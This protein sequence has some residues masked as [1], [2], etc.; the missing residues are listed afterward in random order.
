M[1]VFE[2]SYMTLVNSGSYI[3]CRESVY[4]IQSPILPL[5]SRQ[6]II[7]CIQF[8]DHRVSHSARDAR[9]SLERALYRSNGPKNV[10]KRGRVWR[11]EMQS[12]SLWFQ[13]DCVSELT[14]S[15]DQ[16]YMVV[17]DRRVFA[18]GYVTY[19]PPSIPNLKIYIQVWWFLTRGYM[20]EYMKYNPPPSPNPT[21][22]SPKI[23]VTRYVLKIR[24]LFGNQIQ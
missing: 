3:V 21:P 10:N 17:Y 15:K 20:Q 9:A 19:P 5:N 18:R 23:Y 22:K 6:R 8:A 24:H 2:L 11:W 12:I 4:P 16:I 14:L 13:A 7:K 1:S